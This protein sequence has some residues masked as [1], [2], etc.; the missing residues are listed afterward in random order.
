VPAAAGSG[1]SPSANVAQ[2]PPAQAAAKQ[3]P[4]IGAR[5][6]IDKQE[7]PDGRRTLGKFPLCRKAECHGIFPLDELTPKG[8]P[9]KL[10]SRM[11]VARDARIGANGQFIGDL[12][13]SVG[14]HGNL[15]R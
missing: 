6:F 4:T 11:R 3:T 12:T 1:L 9:K 14:R 13:A 2:P 10:I 5:S 15:R 7:L 8:W